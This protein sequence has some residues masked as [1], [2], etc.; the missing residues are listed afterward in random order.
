MSFSRRQSQWANSALVV[1]VTPEDMR[2][3]L[4]DWG[5]AETAPARPDSSP[6]LNSDLDQDPLVVIRWQRE[7]ERRAAVM[8]GGAMVAP[9]QRITD[10]LNELD[11][12]TA[13]TTPSSIV[14]STPPPT[15]PTL[16]IPT[17]LI[18]T[19]LNTPTA[20]IRS[21][22]RLGVKEA[23]LHQL[24]PSYV[25]RTLQAALKDFDRRLP[26]FITSGVCVKRVG[27]ESGCSVYKCVCR[28]GWIEK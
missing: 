20:P 3:D 10:F 5:V 21:S 9:V 22:Y 23:P 26:G 6:H 14:N 17:T 7:M 13:T 11:P 1:T 25:T 18:P 16:T 19:T 27:R 2:R 28:E 12:S 8:G 15:A 4:A 24:Y